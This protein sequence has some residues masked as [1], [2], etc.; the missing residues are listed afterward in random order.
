M[1]WHQVVERVV[2]QLEG[3]PSVEGAFLGGSL[4]TDTWDEF[5]DI[6]MGVATADSAAD[7][8]RAYGRRSEL[9]ATVGD[10]IHI[11][12]KQWDHSRMISLLYGKSQFPP[13]GLE[14]DIFFGQ[15]R[16]IREL[17]P[18]ARF[19]VVFD[20]SGRLSR[21]LTKLDRVRRREEVR[22]D[23][24]EQMT[25]FPFDLNHAIKAEARRDMFNYQFV[26][27]RM[28]AAVFS[29]AASRQGAVVRGSKR[30]SLYLSEPEQ[31]VIL[32]SYCEFSRQAIHEL[33]Q[34][35]LSLLDQAR[36]EYGIEGDVEHLQS[37]L[38][39]LS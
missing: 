31:Q 13:I 11:L 14:L 5:S 15:V 8:D 18:G 28:R 38:S 2:R 22:R 12:E 20:R 33:V 16:Y 37:A 39:Q 6:D 23:L 27:E 10:P 34:F 32:R 36:F 4:V 3:E 17:M 25:T 9:A 30:A 19:G 24:V 35:Y 26:M 21:E 7:V 29:A 1:E